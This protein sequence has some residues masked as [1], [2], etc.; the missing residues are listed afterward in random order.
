ML[1]VEDALQS[2]S[3]A[4]PGV[5]ISSGGVTVPVDS[6]SWSKIEILQVQDPLA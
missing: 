3:G 1:Q 5:R 2:S 6:S 4:L